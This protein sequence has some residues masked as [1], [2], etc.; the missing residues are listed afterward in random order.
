[1]IRRFVFTSV[2]ALGVIFYL[3]GPDMATSAARTGWYVIGSGVG[4]FS[5]TAP[6]MKDGLTDAKDANDAQAK[7]DA[8]AKAKP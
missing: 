3:A 1:V 5:N 7:A 8:K 6:H 2:L 4:T